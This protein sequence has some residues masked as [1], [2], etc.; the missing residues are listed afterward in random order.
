VTRVH[1]SSALGY[2]DSL[3]NGEFACTASWLITLHYI[4]SHT[5]RAVGEQHFDCR[6]IIITRAL[7][8]EFLFIATAAVTSSVASLTLCLCVRSCCKT[9]RA[10]NT[11]L[12][13][14]QTDSQTT[15]VDIV[16]QVGV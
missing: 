13:L 8:V 4:T 14:G 15:S 12:G 3:P 10:I 7:Y 16:S 11:T 5:L 1:V 6:P 9:A 2:V